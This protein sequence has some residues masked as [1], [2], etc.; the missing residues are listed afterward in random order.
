VSVSLFTSPTKSLGALAAA[1]A[2]VAGI[3]A[4]AFARDGYVVDGASMFNAATVSRRH[5][6]D[7]RQP[8]ARQRGRRHFF[9]TAGQRRLIL[10][11]KGGKTG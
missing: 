2:L 6:A 8:N 10:L 5:R 7:A 3:A 1:L 9:E 4:P 11:R